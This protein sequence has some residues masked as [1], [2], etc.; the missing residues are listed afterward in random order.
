M[1]HLYSRTHSRFWWISYRDP[2][3]GRVVRRSTGIA[4]DAAGAKQRANAMLFERQRAE[5]D[6][7]TV[8]EPERWERWVSEFLDQRYEH[9]P[10]TLQRV[11]QCWAALSVYLTER[12]VKVPRALTYRVCA[13]Y[14]TWRTHGV[15]GRKAVHHNTAVVEMKFFGVI[16]REAVRSGLAPG[17]P[18]REVELRR[19]PAKEKDEI[20]IEDQRRIERAL[21]DAPAWMRDHWLVLMK[22]GCRSDEAFVPMERINWT[23]HT[24]LLRLKGGRLHAT[25]MHPDVI[26]LAAERRRG[27]H[28]LLIDRPRYAPKLWW[29]F[30]RGLR[31]QFSIHCTRVT[32]ITRLLRA[33]C[34]T[35]QVCQLIGHTEEVNRIY[36]RLK[37]SDARPLVSLL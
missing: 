31:M 9:S 36:R 26:A 23:D 15:K 35:A 34:T 24:M 27:G 30:F 20:G 17:N 12:A 6:A 10:K 29:Q 1:A 18:V 25:P 28:A 37:A 19:L 5:L 21:V 4:L 16:M 8:R 32:V 7:P 13:D 2:A 33:G 3:T 11:R 14:V 22:T